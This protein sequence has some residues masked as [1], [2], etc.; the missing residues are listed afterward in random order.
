MKDLANGLRRVYH[1]QRVFCS[2][3]GMFAA[4]PLAFII[5]AMCYIRLEEGPI[6]SK[7]KFP[8]V[9]L[10]TIGIACTIFAAIT[11]FLKVKT[12]SAQKTS[13][14][15][16]SFAILSFI[17]P[18]FHIHCVWLNKNAQQYQNNLPTISIFTQAISLINHDILVIL[19]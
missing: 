2:P 8:A 14:H 10:A 5:P 1:R 13:F 17:F 19:V 15:I 7:T 6:M 18:Y 11:I 3:Q 4:I 9:I 16:S 12:F